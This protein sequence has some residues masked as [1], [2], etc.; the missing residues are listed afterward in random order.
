M[1]SPLHLTRARYAK[2]SAA[3]LWSGYALLIAIV[4]I[5]GLGCC[6]F[7]LLECL[8]EN[9]TVHW[10]EEQG[11]GNRRAGLRPGP[12]RAARRAR[13]HTLHCRRSCPGDRLVGELVRGFMTRSDLVQNPLISAHR[14]DWRIENRAVNTSDLSRQADG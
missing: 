2:I 5:P 12:A 6:F 10:K 3:L 11:G 4:A 7:G 1:R 13:G 14:Q 9:T 8:V